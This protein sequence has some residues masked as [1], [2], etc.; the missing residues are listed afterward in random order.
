MLDTFYLSPT[1]SILSFSLRQASFF[2]PPV[3]PPAARVQSPPL[4]ECSVQASRQERCRR[5]AATGELQVCSAINEEG[6]QCTAERR[7]R[8]VDCKHCQWEV[9][10][11]V[12]LAAFGKGAQ[13]VHI[14][15]NVIGRF[16]LG[17]DDLVVRRSCGRADDEARAHFLGEGAE[18]CA[19][20]LGVAIHH[21][22]VR[23]AI[24][25]P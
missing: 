8:V 14:T 9:I 22:H 23:E 5:E 1:V 25:G 2:A 6:R 16:Y 21:E 17:V 7:R 19:R 20:E 18:H 4:P 12:L 10:V 3:P 24:T 13:R 11:I 15:D